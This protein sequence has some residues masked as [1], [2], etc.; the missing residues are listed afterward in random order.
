[1]KVTTRKIYC[2]NCLK[3]VMGSEKLAEDTIKVSCPNCN[4]VVWLWNGTYWHQV[5]K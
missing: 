2:P 3:L 4:E 1:M 5:R